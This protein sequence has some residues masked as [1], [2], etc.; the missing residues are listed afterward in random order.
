MTSTVD[1]RELPV[2]FDTVGV[3]VCRPEHVPADKDEC[4]D[5]GNAEYETEVFPEIPHLL[6]L[7]DLRD[8]LEGREES[9]AD[10]DRLKLVGLAYLDLGVHVR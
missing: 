9:V 7:R 2:M 4:T 3:S 6:D 10:T 5:D 8:L 1:T